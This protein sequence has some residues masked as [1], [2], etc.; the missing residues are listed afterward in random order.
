[1]VS[2]KS[3]MA[4]AGG[5][6]KGLLSLLLL[7]MLVQERM[8]RTDYYKVLGVG[9]NANEKDVRKAYKKLSRKFH[10]DVVPPAEKEAAQKKFVQISEA[11]QTLKDPKKREIY[12][13]GRH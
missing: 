3:G 2:S 8:C 4:K 10:P 5:A 13:Q 12:D 1:M 7:C 6:L 9:R 11:Y